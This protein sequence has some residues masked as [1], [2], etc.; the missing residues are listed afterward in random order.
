MLKSVAQRGKDKDSAANC[1]KKQK[2]G[3]ISCK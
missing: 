1:G 3:Q 2:G